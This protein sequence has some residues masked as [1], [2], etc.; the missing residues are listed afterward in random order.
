MYYLTQLPIKPGEPDLKKWGRIKG[1]HAARTPTAKITL[2]ILPSEETSAPGTH[3]PC[4]SSPP[5]ADTN[6]F[7]HWFPLKSP[8]PLLC[9][10][11]GYC[12]HL[13][14]HQKKILHWPFS[15]S[16]TPCRKFRVCASGCSN[17]G[18][19]DHAYLLGKNNDENLA[20]VLILFFF[21][22][23]KGARPLIN[24]YKAPSSP[25]I[26]K[27]FRYWEDSPDDKY[28]L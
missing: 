12:C 4:S 11:T 27:G 20:L 25:N 15:V 18:H 6:G 8:F 10:E 24:I 19:R 28:S 13:N 16:Q 1:R 23:R 26:G 14:H 22:I 2:W 5:W 21:Y 7:R 3:I 17:L 9:L